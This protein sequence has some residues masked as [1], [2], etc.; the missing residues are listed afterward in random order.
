MNYNY[1]RDNFISE[2]KV[3]YVGLILSTAMK[4]TCR[5]VTKVNYEFVSISE[6]NKSKLNYFLQIKNVKVKLKKLHI[7]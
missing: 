4:S 6:L 7:L 3:R 2:H 5:L 1:L